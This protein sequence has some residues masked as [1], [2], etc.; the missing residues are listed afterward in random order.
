MR[1][2][3]IYVGA[4]HAL[5]PEGAHLRRG[6]EVDE[7]RLGD[8]V[9]EGRRGFISDMVAAQKLLGGGDLFDGEEPVLDELPEED[10]VAARGEAGEGNVPGETRTQ[11][12]MSKS[13]IRGAQSSPAPDAGTLFRRTLLVS[14]MPN[15]PHDYSR[16]DSRFKLSSPI[17]PATTQNDVRRCRRFSS[18]SW[19][20]RLVYCRHSNINT[21]GSKSYTAIVTPYAMLTHYVFHLVSSRKTVARFA[22]YVF[23]VLAPYR[24]F[25]RHIPGG[26]GIP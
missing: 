21:V 6:R 8:L 18:S 24:K 16:D 17:L 5:G 11:C 20:F 12:E 7:E 15:N 19:V 22:R 13:E 14:S 1:Y 3:G 23:D 9:D 2:A 26:Y 4:H 10:G 25:R